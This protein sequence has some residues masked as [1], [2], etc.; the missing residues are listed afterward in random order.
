MTPL[1]YRVC[2]VVLVP[3]PLWTADHVG[4]IPKCHFL[5]MRTWAHRILI[6]FGVSGLSG[7]WPSGRFP[8]PLNLVS[9]RS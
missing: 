9:E 8:F 3:G 7:V 5:D 4:L 2:V 6:S 1:F